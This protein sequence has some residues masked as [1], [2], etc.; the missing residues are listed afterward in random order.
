[1][2]EIRDQHITDNYAIYNADCMAVMEGLPDESIGL[3]VYSPPFAQKNGGLY[4]YSDDDRDLS[5]CPTYESFFEQYGHIVKEITRLTPSGRIS[6]VHCMD[7]VGSNTGKGDTAYDF[8]SDIIKLHSENGWG[9]KGRF[10]I[11]KEPFKVRMR[12]MMKGLAHKTVV[13]DSASAMMASADFLLIFQK[14]GENKVPITHSDGL[15]EYGYMG[16]RDMPPE[17]HQHRKFK[18]KQ[19]ENRYSHWIWRQYAYGVWDDIRIDNVLKYKEGRDEGDERH[20]HPLQLDA[21]H[22]AVVLY[23]NP[24]EVVLTPFMG[25]GSEV[26]EAVR[27]GRK[28]V[29]AE[30]K[31]SYFNQAVKNLEDLKRS[32]PEKVA[33]FEFQ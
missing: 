23:S 25:V 26:Y 28:G 7:L 24:E 20:V 6:A 22:R 33:L 11:S 29:G 3:S 19:T 30:L 10:C 15:N 13:D 32:K 21:I 12:T 31:P 2:D 27:L 5:N 9:Y 8:P 18:G 14:A 16:E 4:Q 17:L 1:M